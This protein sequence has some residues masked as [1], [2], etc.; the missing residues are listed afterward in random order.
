MGLLI[1][2]IF[3][4][5]W[6]PIVRFV[7]LKIGCQKYLWHHHQNEKLN[8]FYKDQKYN[9]IYE[10][11]GQSAAFDVSRV[12]T[13]GVTADAKVTLKENKNTPNIY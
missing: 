1:I 7:A 8:H 12:G 11:S 2:Q 10:T 6:F 4:L 3:H 5:I 9:E 13:I